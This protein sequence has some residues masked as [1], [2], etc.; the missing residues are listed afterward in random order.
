[1]KY[2]NV[3]RRDF[4]K[5]SLLS[6]VGFAAGCGVP[7]IRTAPVD[8]LP[9]AN[10]QPGVDPPT[11]ST[12]NAEVLVIGA[13]AAGLGAA[14]A[15]QRMG[16]R[17]I[18]LEARPRIGGRVWTDASLFGV[19]LD[20]GASWVHGIDNNPISKLAARFDA[21]T[22][23]TDYD[24]YQLYNT[25]GSPYSDAQ[26]RS[27]DQRL[28]DL[29]DELE[30]LAEDMDEEDEDDISLG[31][32]VEQVLA[33]KSY[34][35]QEL[36]ELYFSLNTTIEHEYSGALADISLYEVDQGE[37][38][39]GED[40]IFPQGY[41]Q[42]MDGLAEG[43]DIRLGHVAQAISYDQ[44]DGVTVT[45]NHGVFHGDYA[46]VTL[47]LGVLQS[48]AVQFS[49]PLPD[50]KQTA[51]QHLD[52]GILNKV[53]L[54]FPNVFWDREHEMLG[55][56]S[57]HRGQWA[58][59]LNI[60]FYTGAPIL[61]AFNAADYGLQIEALADEDI[62]AGVMTVLQRI[63]GDAIPQPDGWLITR[64]G[65]DPFAGGSYSYIRPHGSGDDLDALAESLD[66]ILFFAGEATSRD[67]AA[68]VHGAYLSGVAAAEEIDG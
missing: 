28:E 7:S 20:L 66:N 33:S 23:L 48:G 22:L 36:R 54:H 29:L 37:D 50:R 39:P 51:L 63:Y 30:A 44:R 42:V 14:A 19:P 27:I 56:V 67:Y 35:A 11:G 43:L 61:L 55:Y 65:T 25:D 47:P 40:V 13:G 68:T 4:F 15:L 46:V 53:Y 12:T 3:S 64:W 31:E 21:Q 18:V 16:Y 57:E 26:M 8:E 9:E 34:S 32:A 59:Y 2:K 52:M 62:I 41:S 10:P 49:P 5:L 17:V 58:E 38:W 6:A 45:A 24:S 60:H 1:M